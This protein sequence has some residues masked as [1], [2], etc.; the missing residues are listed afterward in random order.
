M[1]ALSLMGLL[2]GCATEPLTLTKV[3]RQKVPASLLVPCPKTSLD[4][5]TYQSA[6]EL[7]IAR[8]KDLDECS[9]RLKDIEQ[10]SESQPSP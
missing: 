9:K 3:E 8:G 5:K 10:W 2:A 6:I 4:G 7:A 1:I